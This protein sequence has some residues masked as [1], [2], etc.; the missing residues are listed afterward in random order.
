MT[1]SVGAT[2]SVPMALFVSGIYVD[3]S[4][5][6][7]LTLIAT[8]VSFAPMTPTFVYLGPIV[9][10]TLIAETESGAIRATACPSIATA[11]MTAVAN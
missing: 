4:M 6:A 11:M 5:G 8:P 2:V 9:L 10:R 1:W 7:E 3:R